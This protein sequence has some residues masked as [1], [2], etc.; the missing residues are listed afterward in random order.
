MQA[1][2]IFKAKKYR[3]RFLITHYSLRH[4]SILGRIVNKVKIKVRGRRVFIAG[5][6]K[7]DKKNH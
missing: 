7:K 2:E 6:F 1:R 5:F 4:S 3:K